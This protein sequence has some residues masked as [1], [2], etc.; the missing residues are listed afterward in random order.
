M[1]VLV[2]LVL[3]LTC[4][5]CTCRSGFSSA[6]FCDFDFCRWTHKPNCPMR[7]SIKSYKYR[8]KNQCAHGCVIVSDHAEYCTKLFQKICIG[9][10]GL[11][12]AM[13]SALH[14]GE[15]INPKCTVSKENMLAPSPSK[16][17]LHRLHANT[18]ETTSFYKVQ[19]Q[20]TRRHTATTAIY[21]SFLNVASTQTPA[22]T[23]RRGVVQVQ[24]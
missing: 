6:L 11:R 20:A 13:S 18:M 14:A 21:N 17:S 4:L 7:D 8:R 16:W 9:Q 2:V 5:V 19:V 1:P 23:I 10:Q 24:V 15:L 3:V 12:H 22:S